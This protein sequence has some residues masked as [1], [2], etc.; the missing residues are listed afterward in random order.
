[1]KLIT[2]LLSLIT[3]ITLTACNKDKPEATTPTNNPLAHQVEALEK[4]K[5]LESDMQKAVDD[6][7]K[8]I[9]GQ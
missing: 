8:A 3:L 7:L 2:A 5:N 6:K 9:D 4:A 1:M